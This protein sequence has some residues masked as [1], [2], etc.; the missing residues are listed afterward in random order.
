MSKHPALP[1]RRF[2]IATGVVLAQAGAD[3]RAPPYPVRNSVTRSPVI[4]STRVNILTN[5]R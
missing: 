1:R 4:T 3:G 2:L 5:S